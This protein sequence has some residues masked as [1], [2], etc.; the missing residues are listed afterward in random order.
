VPRLRVLTTCPGTDWVPGQVVDATAEQ[1]QRYL[2][3]CGV[4][5]VREQ[6]IELADAWITPNEARKREKG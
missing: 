4:E 6:R 5:L 1:A 2:A 3:A